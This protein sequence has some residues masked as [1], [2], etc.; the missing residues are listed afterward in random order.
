MAFDISEADRSTSKGMVNGMTAKYCSLEVVTLENRNTLSEIFS[1]GV[2][3]LEMCTVLKG[4][5]VNDLYVFLGQN[6]TKHEFVCENSE[7]VGQ[8]TQDL[9]DH[10][11]RS[12]NACLRWI[13]SMLM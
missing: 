7:G 6:G 3:F 9:R 13:E 2:V 8:F 10:G 11:L 5:T 12:D 1:L 4:R